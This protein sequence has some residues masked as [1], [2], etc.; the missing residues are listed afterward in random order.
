MQ[1]NGCSGDFQTEADQ[2]TCYICKLDGK[3]LWVTFSMKLP[4]WVIFCS[5]LLCF[6]KLHFVV[7]ELHVHMTIYF[8]KYAHCNT[9]SGVKAGT[10]RVQNI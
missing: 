7:D 5:L 3:L 6:C 9:W 2:N 4:L 1:Q 8:I 10:E